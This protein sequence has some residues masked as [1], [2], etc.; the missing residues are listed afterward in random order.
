MVQLYTYNCPKFFSQQTD[1]TTDSQI[2][3]SDHAI[4]KLCVQVIHQSFILSSVENRCVQ[5]SFLCPLVQNSI[6]LPVSAMWKRGPAKRKVCMQLFHIK[7]MNTTSGVKFRLCHVPFMSLS[8]P[9]YPKNQFLVWKSLNVT[10]RPFQ[11][12]NQ[13]SFCCLKDEAHLTMDLLYTEV[14]GKD[15]S[16]ATLNIFIK[17]CIQCKKQHR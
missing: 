11:S 4:V 7:S 16:P 1:K 17:Q 13:V 8:L 5:I 14:N 2:A 3:C 15:W 12:V 10:N 9:P 6:F